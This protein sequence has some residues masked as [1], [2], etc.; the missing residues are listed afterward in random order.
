MTETVPSVRVELSSHAVCRE[1]N[2]GLVMLFD[3]KKGVMYELNETA[4]VIIQLLNKGP[5]DRSELVAAL[6]DEFDA[7][8][9]EIEGELVPFLSD[10]LE[11]GLLHPV[12][13][14]DA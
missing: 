3:R 13:G 12:D 4:A 5:H 1:T 6:T 8:P 2:N 7:T 9:E 11:A 10:F 14:A